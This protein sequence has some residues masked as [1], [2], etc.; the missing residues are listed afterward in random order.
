[1]SSQSSTSSPT[2]G[3]VAGTQTSTGHPSAS[4][5]VLGAQATISKPVTRKA[6]AA[7]AVLGTAHFT[8]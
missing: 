5:G 3:G 1:V 2:S 4:G 8:G 6:R 7:H